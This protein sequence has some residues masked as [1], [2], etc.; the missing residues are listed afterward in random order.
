M[1]TVEDFLIEFGFSGKEAL[2]GIEKIDKALGSV[3]DK[4]R[5]INNEKL[6]LP[7]NILIKDERRP[8][9]P[10][11]TAGKTKRR[12]AEEILADKVSRFKGTRAMLELAERDADK[13]ADAA[14]RFAKATSAKDF[15]AV[16]RVRKEV[17]DLNREFAKSA[18]L[19]DRKKARAEALNRKMFNLKHT[20]S[21]VATALAMM[22]TASALTG[23]GVFGVTRSVLQAGRTMESL[24]ASMI[25][26][27]GGSRQAAKDMKFVK[28]QAMELGADLETSAKAYM[29]LATAS[30]GVISRKDMQALFRSTLEV[31]TALGLTADE[32]QGSIRAFEQMASKGRVT[33]EE[34]KGQLGER[35]PGALALAA[36]AMDTTTGQLFKMME[37]GTLTSEEFLPKMAKAMSDLARSSGGLEKALESVRV[38]EAQLRNSFLMFREEIANRGLNK[39][40]ADLLENLKD[41]LD[42]DSGKSDE[43]RE[44]I[45]RITKASV[46]MADMLLQKLLPAIEDLAE[47][48]NEY[49]D[50]LVELYGEKGAVEAF[51]KDVA[52]GAISLT[53]AIAGLIAGL[54]TLKVLAGA[55]AKTG[56]KS[57]LTGMGLGSVA[58]EIGNGRGS[59]R[60]NR[61]A[62][63]AAAGGFARA[64]L[65][66]LI[67]ALVG[68]AGYLARNTTGVGE[69]ADKLSSKKDRTVLEELKN[70][71]LNVGGTGALLNQAGKLVE[72]SVDFAGLE[73]YISLH[74][75]EKQ[76]DMVNMSDPGAR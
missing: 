57:A 27:S 17:A 39:A 52:D 44:A 31:S 55:V 7:R 54:K 35:L 5:E 46:I 14:R 1:S 58:D 20:I 72:V 42:L 9:G 51:F 50:G 25:V 64:G 56:L 40:Y 3:R 13:A 16:G 41:F 21:G 53:L 10:E 15:E 45:A 62:A 59:R 6:S 11:T 28:E 8:P 12:S 38:K 67:A 47:Q 23:A 63:G 48:F 2:E 73:D 30:Q 76:K 18:R 22:G 75:D 65:P 66:A 29:K 68:G 70:Y 4:L 34:L 61:V 43:T 32:T 71:L 36:K 49:Y 74:V 19:M 33:A 26:A 37:A 24:N 69:M 60:G